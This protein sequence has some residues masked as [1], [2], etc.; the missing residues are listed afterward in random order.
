M[1]L[2][3]LY[4]C[5]DMGQKLPNLLDIQYLN[6]GVVEPS[7]SQ[8]DNVHLSC[9]PSLHVFQTHVTCD[10]CPVLFVSCLAFVTFIIIH[11]ICSKHSRFFHSSCSCTNIVQGSP[12]WSIW[13]FLW[14]LAK[15][16]EVSHCSTFIWFWNSEVSKSFTTLITIKC[17]LWWQKF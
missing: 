16:E 8:Q 9:F 7:E 11:F 2:N 6:T 17:I 13:I 10:T 1:A 12:T 4:I 5:S 14:F 15:P 3:V